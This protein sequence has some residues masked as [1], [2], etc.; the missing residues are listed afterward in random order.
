MKHAGSAAPGK[1]SG[2]LDDIRAFDSLT[3]K[4][5]GIFYLKRT[6]FLHFH[7]D[8]AGV[9]ADIKLG[10]DWVRFPANKP[11]EHRRIVR[12]VG[13]ALGDRAKRRT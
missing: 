1:L 5:V 11:A 12:A 6:A 13:A 9:F 4:S 7:E 8:P 2:L 10:N 3:E